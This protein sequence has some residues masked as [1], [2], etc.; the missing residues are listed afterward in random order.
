MVGILTDKL[1]EFIQKIKDIQNKYNL[2]E[3][4]PNLKSKTLRYFDIDEMYLNGI[5]YYNSCGEVFRSFENFLKE[6]LHVNT[7]FTSRFKAFESFEKKWEKNS[8]IGQE[9]K[10]YK[11]CNDILG[12]RFIVDCKEEDLVNLINSLKLDDVTII[13]FYSN[14]KTND[15]GYRGIHMYFWYNRRGFPIEFQI[16]TIKDALLQFYTHEIIYKGS[17]SVSKKQYAKELRNWL[18]LIPS[19]P[20]DLELDY[21]RYLYSVLN[22]D[23]EL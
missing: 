20:S 18:N 6:N 5:D 11:A 16:W 21:I 8:R 14:K 23:K 10:F 12:Y 1:D 19:G 13:D 4:V 22:K 17:N 2:P 9:K 15:D 7:R 3:G